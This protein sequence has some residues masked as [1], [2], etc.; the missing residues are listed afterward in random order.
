MKVHFLL[1]IASGIL[2]LYLAYCCLLFFFQRHI[3]F[4]RYQIEAPSE[5]GNNAD[6]EKIWLST[7]Y[8]DVEAWFLPPGQDHGRSPAVI[9][10]HGNAELIDFWPEDLK[11][12]TT[13]GIGLLLVEYPGYGRSEGTPSQR[14]IGQAFLAAYD[15]LVAREDVDPSRIVLFGRSIGGG[16]VC[17]LA[18]KR[19]SAALILMST[20]TGVRSFASNFLIPRFLVL[21]PF[22]NLSVVGSYP[23]PVLII[24]GKNDSLIP[25]KHALALHHAAQQGQM[26]TYDCRHNDCPPSWD[27]FWQNVESFLLNA[28]IIDNSQ[29]KRG[30]LQGKDG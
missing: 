17:A 5:T 23:G 18:A 27:T 15:A 24:H 16:A 1:K 13:L 22:D 14:S 7:N 3:L 26:L 4:P 6:Q 9:F 29:E 8:G 12:F 19:P 2:F 28:G 20:F 30:R 11:K 21:D 25:Y 10:A